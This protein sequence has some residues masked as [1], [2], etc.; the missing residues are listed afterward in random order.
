MPLPSA[1]SDT[2]QPGTIEISW[3]E[4]PSLPALAGARDCY[5]TDRPCCAFG[6]PGHIRDRFQHPGCGPS[7]VVPENPTGECVRVTP[8]W[9]EVR[10]HQV[11]REAVR[12]T[13]FLWVCE[14]QSPGPCEGPPTAAPAPG[15]SS[16]DCPSSLQP[17]CPICGP[18]SWPQPRETPQSSKNIPQTSPPW[19][20]HMLSGL[21]RELSPKTPSKRLL[22]WDA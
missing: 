4:S 19:L 3:S 5:K 1:P 21:P 10:S 13:T 16:P 7:L 2:A 15:P 17:Q 18:L 6:V 11:C 20:P 12:R 8:V 9:K 22:A 14:E